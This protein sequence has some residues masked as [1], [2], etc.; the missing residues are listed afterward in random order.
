MCLSVLPHPHCSVPRT[1]DD[2]VFK[3][4]PADVPHARVMTGQSGFYAA[5]QDVINDDFARRA[6][7]V[8]ES[9]AGAELRGE[10]TADERV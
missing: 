8:D 9:L 1:T 3:R 2:V 7:R 4:V 5:C 6:A 10:A